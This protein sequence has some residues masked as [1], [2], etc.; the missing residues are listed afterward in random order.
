[1][2]EPFEQEIRYR[3]LKVLS[4]NSKLSQRE[5]AK[6]MGISLGKV[7]YCLSEMASKGFIKIKRFQMS[8]NRIKYL[9]LLTPRGMEEKAR[10]T[11]NFLRRKILEYQAIKKQIRDLTQEVEEERLVDISA[12][13]TLDVAKRVH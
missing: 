1:M 5:M 6:R 4:L 7:N 12:E 10:I 8:K 9:Y 3:L 2:N 11:L 13:D